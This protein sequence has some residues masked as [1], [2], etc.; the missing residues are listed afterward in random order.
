MMPAR[1]TAKK[2]VHGPVRDVP[3]GK[4]V[5]R[6]VLCDV[7]LADIFLDGDNPRLRFLLAK[8]T[9]SATQSEL[10]DM[11]MRQPA[12]DDLMKRVRDNGGL[13]EPIYVRPDLRV[14]EG[15]GRVAVCRHLLP[16]HPKLGTV[17]AWVFTDID[18][19]DAAVL[20]G[21]LH[22]TGKAM[23]P[24]HEQAGHIHHMKHVL[25]MSTVEIATDVGL[26]EAIVK[27]Q[28]AAYNAMAEHVLPT[29]G[30]K[31][32]AKFSYF[33]ELFKIEALREFRQKT[34]NVKVFAQ[35]V[36]DG[37]LTKGAQVRLLP[38]ILEHGEL[39]TLK[40]DGIDEA[41]AAIGKVDA[42]AG[43]PFF[44]RVH[45]MA[46]SLSNAPVKVIQKLRRDAAARKVLSELVTAASELQKE[47]APTSSKG[48]K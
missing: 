47:A 43:D 10:K 28:L 17:P 21:M 30:Q 41:L 6:A 25:K 36:V 7:P 48:R 34:P 9:A 18:D 44:K 23:W 27:R 32:M 22:V 45:A 35:L 16:S 14:I 1:R 4:K 5:R 37:T 33:Y 2:I 29:M 39:D 31:G 8:R 13:V 3:I 15:N 46:T 20:Q 24:A 12:S 42:T 19:R 26:Q 40:K 11:L 38:A